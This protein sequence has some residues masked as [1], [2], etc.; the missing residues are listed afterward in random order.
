M[1]LRALAAAKCFTGASVRATLAAGTVAQARHR[2][3][4]ATA[5]CCYNW[6]WPKELGGGEGEGYPKTDDDVSLALE[7]TAGMSRA[8]AVKAL[9]E[10]PGYENVRSGQLTRWAR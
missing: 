7:K 5:P 2:A 9:N 10:I 3:I 6:R 8:T 4:H 1:A